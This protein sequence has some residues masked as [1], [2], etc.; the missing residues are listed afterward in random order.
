MKLFDKG[1][2]YMELKKRLKI[3]WAL[4]GHFSIIDIGF[5]YYV[6][7]FINREDYEPVLMDGLWMIGDNYLVLRERV[8]NFV[9]EDKITKLTAWVRIPKLGLEYFNKHFLL[10]KIRKKIGRVLKLNSSTSNVER[11]QFTRLCV[12]VDLTEP[13]LSK[14]Q[15][16]G[17]IW[18]IQ[19]EGLRMMCFYYGK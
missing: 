2:N 4:Q 18:K 3:K 17:R 7:R 1:V 8:P 12:E 15:L 19:Y 9:P 10:N 14:F 11:G 13:R 6:T 5:D 16:N